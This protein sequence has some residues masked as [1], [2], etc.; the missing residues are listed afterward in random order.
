MKKRTRLTGFGIMLLLA[1]CMLCF[2]ASAGSISLK[3]DGSVVVDYYQRY[4]QYDGTAKKPVIHTV[5]FYKNGNLNNP[6]VLQEGRD[7]VLSFLYNVDPG[8]G[9]VYLKGIGNYCDTAESFFYI[10]RL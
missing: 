9:W 2:P 7:Y 5:T 8:V 3:N 6:T 4:I 1:L 10:Y